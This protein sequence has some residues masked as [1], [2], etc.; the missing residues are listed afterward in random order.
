MISYTVPGITITDGSILMTAES[1]KITEI[2][3]KSQKVLCKM[4]ID[5]GELSYPEGTEA[6]KQFKRQL[7]IAGW[8]PN[9]IISRPTSGKI[10]PAPAKDMTIYYYKNG[11]GDN[12]GNLSCSKKTWKAGTT[13]YGKPYNHGSGSLAV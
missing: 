4:G 5:F 7:G 10:F 2:S 12:T 11:T 8:A 3:S 6:N 1:A 13:Y 9:T